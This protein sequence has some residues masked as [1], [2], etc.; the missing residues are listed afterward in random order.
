MRVDLLKN[1]L[2]S[3]KGKGLKNVLRLKQVRKSFGHA[4]VIKGIDF[5]LEKGSVAT[6]LGPSGTGKTTLLRCINFL[7][8]AD[9][10][11]I[12][13]DDLEGDFQAISYKKSIEFRRKTAMVFQN[14]NLFKNKTALENVMEGLTVVKGYSKESARKISLEEIEKVGLL[15]KIDCYPYELSGGQ[16]Q[17]IAISRSLALKPKVLLLDEP[18]SSLDPERSAEVLSVL[19]GIA[20]SG[21]T[22][23]IATHEME[24][25][26]Q[27]SH[28]LIFMENGYIVEQGSPEQIFEHAQNARTKKFINKSDNRQNTSE[29]NVAL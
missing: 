8:S 9:S 22:M 14:Y 12:Q 21:M 20:K 2:I 4:E 1:E 18:T 17:R 7:E 3:Q 29:Y 5:V 27:V 6:L 25:A 16:Q 11:H 28:Q 13:I 24:F 15:D 19:R 10:G 26:R 23:L